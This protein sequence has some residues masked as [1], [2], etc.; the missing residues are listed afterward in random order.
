MTPPV[1]WGI[2]RRPKA[3]LGQLECSHII[4]LQAIDG[5]KIA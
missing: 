2:L 4:R 5:L 1:G 3:P